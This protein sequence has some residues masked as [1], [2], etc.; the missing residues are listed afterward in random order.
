MK[1]LLFSFEGRIGR[2]TW[3]LTTLALIGVMVLV[4][5]VAVGLGFVSETLAMIAMVV[6][7]VVMLGVLWAT[8]AIQAKRWH[9]VDKS[10]WW[11][12]IN[13]VPV[14]GGLYALVML[15]FVQGTVGRNQFGEDPVPGGAA[16]NL[17][18][19]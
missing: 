19:A 17:R 15:G 12:L 14:V 7:L 4:Q 16:G 1:T 3:W 9:D 8:L 11:I 2:K 10:G 6:A 13:L 18:T 5:V